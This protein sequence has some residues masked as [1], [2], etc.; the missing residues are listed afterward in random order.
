MACATHAEK[1]GLANMNEVNKRKTDATQNQASV[2]SY[3]LSFEP[4]YLETMRSGCM[5][6]YHEVY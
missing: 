6:Y 4:R 5:I 3:G 1:Q 2:H